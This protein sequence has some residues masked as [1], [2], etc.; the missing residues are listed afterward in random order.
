VTRL[1]KHLGQNI[2]VDRN[3]IAKEAALAGDRRDSIV[4]EIGPG[5]GMLTKELAK[6]AKKVIAIEKDPEIL[7]EAKRNADSSNIE[8]ILADAMKMEWP[9]FD[10][11]VSN[12]PYYLSSEIIFKLLEQKFGT[13]VL[14]C[15]KEFGE[16]M[17]GR[18]GKNYSRLTVNAQLR[19][20]VELCGA[21]SKT[22]FMPIPKVDSVIVRLTPKEAKLPEIF[23]PLTRAIFSHKKKLL[24][25]ALADSSG[26][27]GLSKEEAKELFRGLEKRAIELKPEEILALSWKIQEQLTRRQGK[28]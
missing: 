28:S 23:G 27:L 7:E 25:N 21:V 24:K 5:T 10:K 9:R 18:P 2:L 13:A 4:L 1:K 12:L 3:I 8:W 19:A 16:R 17:A 11:M 15:Q 26:E 6:H 20:E 14:I 22:C